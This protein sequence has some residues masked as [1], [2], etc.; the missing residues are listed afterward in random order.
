[1]LASFIGA[2]NWSVVAVS[3]FNTIALI[4]LG[5]TVLLNA[6]RPRWGTYVVGGGLLMGGLFF[7]GHTTVV[8]R[9]LFVIDRELAIWWRVLWV[10]FV[11]GPYLWYVVMAWFSGALTRPSH[12]IGLAVVSLIGIA[13]LLLTVVANPLP[14]Y[15]EFRSASAPPI[16]LL[17]GIPVALLVYPVFSTLCIILTLAVLRLPVTSDRFMG[18]LARQRARPWLIAASGVL[19]LVSLTVGAAAAWVLVGVSTGLVDLTRL[20][21]II[22]LHIIDLLVSALIAVVVVFMG[23]AIVSYE[24]FTGKSLPRGGLLRYWRNSLVLAAGYGTLVAWSLDLPVDPIYRLMFATVLMTLFYALLSWRSYAERER[25]MQRLRPFIASQHLYDQLLGPENP[26]EINLADPFRALCEEVLDAQS[27]TLIPLGPLAPLVPSL[28]YPL[29]E[30]PT[31]TMDSLSPELIVRLSA[32]N[33]L[34]VAIDPSE[35]NGAI[36]AIPLWSERGLI[37]VLLLAAKR[38]EAIY[39]QE[40]IEIARAAAER[41]IDTR[42]SAALAQRLVGLQRRSLAESQVADRR[43]RRVLHDDVLPQIHAAML[44][45]GER[46]DAA[47]ALAALAG[48]HRQIADLL[49]GMPA[50]ASSEIARLGVVEALR[51]AATREM[52][53]AFD[54]VSWHADEQAQAQAERLPHLAGEVLFYAARE[55]MRNAARHGRG[56]TPARHLHLGVTVRAGLE[57]SR[58]GIL[59]LI[60]DDGVGM[61]TPTPHS[62][63]GRGL[64]LHSTLLAVVG[65]SL[66][67]ERR[68]DGG[69]RV[70]ITLPG[71]P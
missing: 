55:A 57:S 3:I 9:D 58:A 19:L 22:I 47:E 24:I 15:E 64:A 44:T 54:E 51:S 14:P 63:G 32:I 38:G 33:Q 25:S 69:T 60:E 2:L 46:A 71:G 30:R 12:Q 5:L 45:L 31:A 43:T 52:A 16:L 61:G 1:M 65:G 27:A 50:P 35:Y 41:L 17:A 23:K 62:T 68:A 10:P 29:A 39:T 37:G 7:T 67:T 11:A 8:A 18:D 42:A 49:H 20:R 40:E 4:W 70:R 6:E 59:V 26:T 48:A 56:T 34:C 53:G 13:A 21:T 66:T 28:A 36:W